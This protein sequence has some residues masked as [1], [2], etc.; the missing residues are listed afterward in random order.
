MYS[1][2]VSE[3]KKKGHKFPS[4]QVSVFLEVFFW[5]VSEVHVGIPDVV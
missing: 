2:E 1:G 4:S 3:K 5:G